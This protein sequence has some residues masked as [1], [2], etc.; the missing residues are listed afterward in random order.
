MQRRIVENNMLVERVLL[1][2]AGP[3]MT[4][5]EADHYRRVQPPGARAGLAVIPTEIC[6]ARPLLEELT[7][8]VPEVLGDRPALA[9]WGLR[10]RV[11]PA[12][13]SI[14]RLSAM[15]SDLAVVELP[16]SNHYTPEEAPAELATAI[17]N[18]FAGR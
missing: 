4:P 2:R 12:Q 14:R 3:P 17:A 11:F 7:R 8:T 5:D 1:G 10:D 16:D 9:V 15:F 13:R 18:R 6:A